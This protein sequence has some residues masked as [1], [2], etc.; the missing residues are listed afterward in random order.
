MAGPPAPMTGPRVV[1]VRHDALS[2][3]ARRL[4]AR[5]YQEQFV[6][7]RLRVTQSGYPTVPLAGDDGLVSAWVPGRTSLVFAGPSAAGEPYLRAHDALDRIPLFERYVATDAMP[8]IDELRLKPGWVL[9]TCSGRNFGP[10][11][12]VDA[13]LATC[14]MTDIMRLAP[15]DSDAGFYTLAFLLSDTGQTLLK[16]DPA[17][18][19]INHLSPLDLCNIP[20]P[21]LDS[22]DYA[23]I[24]ALMRDAHKLSEEAATSVESAGEEL[25]CV[26]GLP[27]T[28]RSIWPL[29]EG[30]PRV[31]T[32]SSA[33]VR[34]RLDAEF[35][36]LRHSEARAAVLSGSS[37]TLGSAANLRVL[38]RYRRLYVDRPHGTPILAGGQTHQLH[39]VALKSISRRS[40]R[41][42][43]AYEIRHG[44]SLI[45]C[46]GRAEGDL[47]RPA[48]VLTSWDGWMASNH[49]MRIVPRD[50]DGGYLFAALRLQEVQVQFKAVATGSVVDALDE[51]TC[52]PIVIP[53]LAENDERRLGEAIRAAHQNWVRAAELETKA[54][55]I[56]ETRLTETYEH[57]D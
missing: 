42:P 26:L 20:V 7:S 13:R 47:G 37:D 54:I 24:A 14:I 23:A 43:N 11:R 27:S 28:R 22:E 25:R 53:R 46:D 9:L 18:S 32:V 30:S 5:Y 41:D 39:P 38:G 16:R 33:H 50:I 45:G 4:D 3:G 10:C 15:R 6:L 44:W 19:V 17:G 36:G 12:Y 8:T 51:L 2:D 48:F 52:S 29:D 57:A 1:T 56:L 31:A 55:S 34:M 35:H 40:F 21:V 49:L